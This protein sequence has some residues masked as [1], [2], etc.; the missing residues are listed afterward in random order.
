MQKFALSPSVQDVYLTVRKLHRDQGAP[1]KF[2]Y[3]QVSQVNL[4]TRVIWLRESR[5]HQRETQYHKWD[6]QT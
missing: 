3:E 1:H 6:K 5:V 4:Q 2:L